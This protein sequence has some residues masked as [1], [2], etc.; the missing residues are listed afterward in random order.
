MRFPGNVV[1]RFRDRRRTPREQTPRTLRDKYFFRP[2][3][4]AGIVRQTFVVTNRQSGTV[5]VCEIEQDV[6]G[7]RAIYGPATL[8]R[9]KPVRASGDIV[10]STTA[11]ADRAVQ[12]RS[13]FGR[14]FSVR[15]RSRTLNRGAGTKRS[16][17]RF[18]PLNVVC[19]TTVKKR[20]AVSA[21]GPFARGPVRPDVRTTGP[22]VDVLLGTRV[23]LRRRRRTIVRP[24]EGR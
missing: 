14:T 1:A 21:V 23:F 3:G 10:F 16:P 2:T 13:D 5:D 7:K 9:S 22:V 12:S 18:D 20:L 17:V 4:G 11:T 19:G 8:R 6:G 15:V 24:A